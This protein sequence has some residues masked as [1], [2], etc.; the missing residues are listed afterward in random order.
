M[1]ISPAKAFQSRLAPP[2]VTQS[3]ALG[4]WRRTSTVNGAVGWRRVTRD[5]ESGSPTR[6]LALIEPQTVLRH[7]LAQAVATFIRDMRVDGYA[8]VEDVDPGPARLVL[9]GADPRRDCDAASLQAK[10][11]ALR[12][13]CGE[14]PIGAV[15]A[16]DDVALTRILVA[17]GVVGILRHDASLAVAVAAIRL[18]I[19]GGS[20]LPAD[21]LFGADD[22][23]TRPPLPSPLPPTPVDPDP[24]DGGEDCDR[25]LTSRE[26]DVLRILRE[27]RQN[28]VIAFELGISEST[29]KVHLRNIMKKLNASNRTQAALGARVG[30]QL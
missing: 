30:F 27:G 22:S 18:M 4:A 21:A 9:I 23:S 12:E 29:V 8:R 15:M 17:L 5:V 1:T 24:Y 14:A 25:S 10:F 13:L 3:L 6:R 19:V 26:S 20:C 11:Q 7:G 2:V 16:R 28:K